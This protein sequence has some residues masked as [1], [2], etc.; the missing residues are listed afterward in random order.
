M[1]PTTVDH[2]ELRV[3]P[4][5]SINYQLVDLCKALCSPLNSLKV[6]PPFRIPSRVY[7]DIMKLT[8]SSKFTPMFKFHF[9]CLLLSFAEVGDV[10]CGRGI[11]I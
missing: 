3:P 9:K 7:H 10:T 2:I 1:L 6:F 11:V 8:N 5:T 4:N